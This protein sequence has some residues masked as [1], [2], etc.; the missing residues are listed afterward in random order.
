MLLFPFLGLI[1]LSVSVVGMV[2][3][4]SGNQAVGRAADRLKIESGARITDHLTRFLTLPHQIN[5]I[6]AAALG[7][8]LVDTGNQ[9]A[10]ARYF[11]KQVS[12]F[13]SVTSINFSNRNG[14]LV[15]AGREGSGDDLYMILTDGFKAGPFRKYAVDSQGRRSGQIRMIQ[16]FDGRTRPWYVEAV[17]KKKPVWSVPYALFTG[18][19]LSI[20]AALSVMDDRNRLLGV[21]SVDLFLS[22]LSQFLAQLNAG[23][24]GRSFILERSGLMIATST[25]EKPFKGSPETADYSRKEIQD[26]TDLTTRAAAAA[27]RDTFGRYHQI[28]DQ[29]LFEFDLEGETQW[30][31]VI[32]FKDPHGLDW[33]I[34]TTIPAQAF[35]AYVPDT[36]RAT[37]GLMLIT[38]AVAAGIGFLICRKILRPVSE[39]KVAAAALSR[40]QW[41]RQVG[42]QGRISEIR[43]LTD[44]FNHMTR[45]MKQMFAGLNR[46]IGERKKTE[47]KYQTL[48][49]NL[50]E[51]VYTLDTQ[52]NF[53]Y[54]SPSIKEL[55]GYAPEEVVGRNFIEFVRPEDIGGRREHYQTL[56]GGVA[57]SAENRLLRKDGRSVWIKT[58][59]RPVIENGSITGLQGVL[60]DISELKSAEAQ[61]RQLEKAESLD[62]MAGAVAHHYNNQL[63]AVMG[64]LEL[65]LIQADETDQADLAG[66]LNNAMKAVLRAS[67]MG[68]AMLALLGNKTEQ[69]QQLDLVETCREFLAD[70]QIRM[71]ETISLRGH[72]P[73]SGVQV[74]ANAQKVR[75]L[76]EYLVQNAR[77]AMAD[78]SGQIRIDMGMANP[79]DIPQQ[80]RW[81]L[82]FVPDAGRYVRV[83]VKDQGEGIAAARVE[84]IFD[85][86]FPPGSSAGALG[87]PFP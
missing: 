8:G 57:D 45:Q 22:H 25:G 62:R 9:S 16:H 82:T 75:E 44:A 53:T 30:G 85:P 63:S 83:S 84:K 18:Q 78:K 3:M 1:L 13:D 69:L 60:T 15:N 34:V 6:H 24:E 42:Y 58:C 55:S 66:V 50:T 2:S 72:L 79:E 17:E 23:P 64:S 77:E 37:F 67:R 33:L 41:N 4:H 29:A 52:G 27:I 26:S 32:P 20:S 40:G 35:M 28:R 21:V 61:I 76:L 19:D 56:T 68:D 46:E 11:Q 10:L 73:E 51:I 65:A 14:G 12:I 39:L 54:V 31:M 5:Q 7:S 48:V 71:P 38:M 80:P 59:S 43:D 81:P 36:R 74:M 49:E 70:L 47:K 87:F 86:F